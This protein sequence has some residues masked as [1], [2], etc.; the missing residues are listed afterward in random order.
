MYT[1][2][3]LSEISSNFVW[4]ETSQHLSVV[5]VSTTSVAVIA[6]DEFFKKS[7]SCLIM[8]LSSLRFFS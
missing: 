4:L 3:H 8:Q 6:P 5:N 2:T 7:H 1:P